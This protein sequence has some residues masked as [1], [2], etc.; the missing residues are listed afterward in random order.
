MRRFWLLAPFALIAANFQDEYEG[1]LREIEKGEAAAR[2]NI[3]EYLSGAQMHKWANEEYNLA[4]KLDSDCEKARKKTGYKKNNGG[5]WEFDASVKVEMQNKKTGP[6]ADR[7]RGEYDKKIASMGKDYAKKYAELAAWCDKNNKK[8]EAVANYKRAVELDPSNEKARKALGFEKLP[9]GGWIGPFEKE[10]RKEMKEGIAKAPKGSASST[11]LD[12][13]KAF[14]LTKQE[15]EHFIVASPHLAKGQL[16]DLIQ[17]AEHAYAMWHKI[18][19]QKNLFENNKLTFL[20]LKDKSQH[21]SY[22]DR[23][24]QGE[25]A[26]K[27]LAKKSAGNLG[28]PL[29]E[30]YQ[31][32][33]DIGSLQDYVIHASI[34]LLMAFFAEGQGSQTH[35]PIWVEEG[36]AYYFTRIM[37]DTAAWG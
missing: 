35:N 20:L 34:Q 19:N 8:E 10:I 26:K 16:E 27:D 6:E 22:V 3:G 12:V 28:F 14:T 24:Y 30:A 11:A 17:H 7:V 2:A 25:G 29:T 15:S 13:D 36:M 31:G 4:I 21:E 1:K 23:F 9:K 33:R 37:K 18:F 32:D 5:E